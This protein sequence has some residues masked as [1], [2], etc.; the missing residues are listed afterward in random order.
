[1]PTICE[2]SVTVRPSTVT[3]GSVTCPAEGNPKL[4]AG[5][6]LILLGTGGLFTALLIPSKRVGGDALRDR[7]GAYNQELERRYDIDSPTRIFPGAPAGGEAGRA[8]LELSFAPTP[9]PR[10]AG[11]TLGGRF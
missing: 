3:D 11:I 4:R 9:M 6:P 2:K 8:R 1:M 10:G 7:V 5:V